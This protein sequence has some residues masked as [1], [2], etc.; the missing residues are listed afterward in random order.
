MQVAFAVPQEPT[1]EAWFPS[2]SGPCGIKFNGR[3][4]HPKLRNVVSV[5][6]QQAV[7]GEMNALMTEKTKVSRYLKLTGVVSF[8]AGF[9]IFMA[10]ILTGMHSNETQNQ[11]VNPLFIAGLA[12]CLSGI[13]EMTASRSVHNS[14]CEAFY[15]AA[16]T[17]LDAHNEAGAA[18]GV[19]WILVLD[20]LH[21]VGARTGRVLSTRKKPRLIAVIGGAPAHQSYN[22]MGVVQNGIPAQCDQV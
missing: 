10:K 16:T 2:T 17:Q 21:V 18:N 13:I 20:D 7:V 14:G 4:S 11:F 19:E 12:L 3:A 15:T 1:N 8:F 5:E 9:G 6:E 22:T